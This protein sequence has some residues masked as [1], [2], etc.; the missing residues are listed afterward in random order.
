M[1]LIKI[2]H[3]CEPAHKL[4]ISDSIDLVNH[5]DWT[6]LV[7]D[8]L[9]LSYDYLKSLELGLDSMEYRYVLIYDAE[10]NPVMAAYFQIIDIEEVDQYYKDYLMRY[11]GES[12]VNGLL[13]ST[14]LRMVMCGNLFVCGENG[15]IAS[16][17]IDE[18][19]GM[20]LLSEGFKRIAKSLDNEEKASIMLVKELYPENDPNMDAF[21]KDNFHPLQIDCNMVLNLPPEWDNLDDY[22]HSM[23]SKFR[24]KAKSVLQRS[25]ALE[26]RSLSDEE[27]QE[28]IEEIDALHFEVVN[29]AEF[30]L[31]TLN[32]ATFVELKRRMPLSFEFVAYYLKG[33]MIGFSASFVCKEF[34]D[35]AHVGINYKF[36]T[37]LALYQRMLYDFVQLALDRKLEQI[38][39]GRTAEQLKSSLG[40]LPV[41]MRLYIKHRN[42]MVNHLMKRFVEKVKPSTF[43]LRRPFKKAEA[44]QW[45]PSPKLS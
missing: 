14:N 38:R 24:T 23:T 17:T 39:F 2:L 32:A 28:A 27:M 42:S 25:A 33:E 22:L 31:G 10:L 15:F 7:K 43:E 26:I 18:K 35:A 9:F 8:S 20:E 4:N 30:S 45:I 1:N 40:A 3:H 41:N 44:D 34:L 21:K 6:S 19:E 36:N 5:K 12:V 13:P 16:E 29:R 11:V 37:E